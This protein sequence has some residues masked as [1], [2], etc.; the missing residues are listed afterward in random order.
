MAAIE[1]ALSLPAAGY[2]GSFN[3]RWP[4]FVVGA[5]WQPIFSAAG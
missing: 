5:F 1:V 4:A 3:L 2:L